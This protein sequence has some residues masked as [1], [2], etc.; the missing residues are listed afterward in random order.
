MVV[1]APDLLSRVADRPLLLAPFDLAEALSELLDLPLA[2]EVVAGE[3]TSSGT[4]RQVPA[5][6]RSL[7]PTA[8]STYVEHDEL[9]VDGVPASWRFF[10]GAVHCSGVDGLA[11]GLAWAA[12]H[13]ADRLAVAAL[14]RDPDAVPLLLAEADLDSLNG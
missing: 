2:G 7:L 14:L 4:V 9:L 3:V 5:A 12:G 8:P 1:E 6:V 10:E 11:R 13:W